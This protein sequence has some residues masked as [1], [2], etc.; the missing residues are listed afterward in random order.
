[1]T[2]RSREGYPQRA[3][4]SRVPGVTQRVALAKRC[5]AERDPGFFEKQATGTPALQRTV[6]QVLH[7][8]LRPGT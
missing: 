5:F 2:A 6:P 1:M 8:A 7:A 3:Q 4:A